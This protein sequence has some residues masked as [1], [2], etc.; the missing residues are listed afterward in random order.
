MLKL[1]RELLDKTQRNKQPVPDTEREDQARRQQVEK[2]QRFKVLFLST[3]AGRQ[4]LSDICKM[5]FVFD[6]TI[7][8]DSHRTL[9]NEGG[10]NLALTILRICETDEDQILNK[11]KQ[12]ETTP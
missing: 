7:G 10:R 9:F 12:Y 6:S 8:A 2:I 3:E 11:P 5:G 4:T 1:F